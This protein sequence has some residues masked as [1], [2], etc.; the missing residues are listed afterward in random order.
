MQ[1]ARAVVVGAGAAGLAAAWR[2]ARSGVAV[3]VLEREDEIG[4]RATSA[5]AGG[6]AFDRG[7][8]LISSADR[9]LL[10]WI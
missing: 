3:L 2:L 1:F 5:A 8:H 4:G 10:A 6:F 7:A 9:T